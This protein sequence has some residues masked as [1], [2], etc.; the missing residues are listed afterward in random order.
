MAA[1]ITDRIKVNEQSSIRIDLDTLVLYFDPFHIKEKSHDAD[2]IFITHDHFDHF[3]ADDIAAVSKQDTVLVCPLYMADDVCLKCISCVVPVEPGNTYSVS[4]ISFDTV[5][6][7]NVNKTFH[8]KE[9]GWCGYVLDISGER[10][11]VAGDTDGLKENFSVTC[12]VALVPIGGKYTMDAK[13]AGN[14]VSLLKPAY[15]IPTHY[16]TVVGKPSDFEM[17]RTFV[18]SDTQVIRKL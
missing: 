11:Y 1:N 18:T 5:P 7:Y 8:R 6:S 16:G 2:I 14:Y 13:E 12:D 4:G 15:A 9:C 3:S 17:F 10:V